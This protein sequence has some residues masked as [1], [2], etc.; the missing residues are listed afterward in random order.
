MFMG[1]E[2]D[3]DDFRESVTSSVIIWLSGDDDVAPGPFALER[4][5]R[6]EVAR[7]AADAESLE[8]AAIAVREWFTDRLTVD[9]GVPGPFGNLAYSLVNAAL[10]LVDWP[11]VVA[12]FLIE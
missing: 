10:D 1:E 3:V 6:R 2:F 12:S 4:Y 8:E 5:G 11:E 7:V 9:P